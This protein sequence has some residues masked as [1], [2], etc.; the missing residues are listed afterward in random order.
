MSSEP[1][2]AER[3]LERVFRITLIAWPRNDGNRGATS[4][5]GIRTK[6]EIGQNARQGVTGRVSALDIGLVAGGRDWRSVKLWRGV[7]FR[8]IGPKF[9]KL[10]QFVTVGR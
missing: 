2:L 8:V 4:I 1:N 3:Q 10:A 7:I 6:E 5:T 9:F